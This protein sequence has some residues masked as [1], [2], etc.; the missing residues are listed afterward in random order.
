MNGPILI[1]TAI[2]IIIFLGLLYLKKSNRMDIIWEIERTF[3][4][5]QIRQDISRIESNYEKSSPK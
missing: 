1:L 3:K 4:K 2:G 5:A